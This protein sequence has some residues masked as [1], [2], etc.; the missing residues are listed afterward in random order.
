[1]TGVL[2]LDPDMDMVRILALIFPEVL[3][4]LRLVE[5]QIRK[6]E[7]WLKAKFQLAVP[8]LVLG[9]SFKS[10]LSPD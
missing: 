2:L 7:I 4:T 1:M 6:V 9:F 3:I 8:V 10:H 5:A